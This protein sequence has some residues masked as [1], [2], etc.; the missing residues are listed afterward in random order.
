MKKPKKD[1]KLD[2]RLTGSQVID[3]E[4]QDILDFII[5]DYVHPWLVYLEFCFGIF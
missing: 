4:L 5:R 1:Y 2:K 3:E